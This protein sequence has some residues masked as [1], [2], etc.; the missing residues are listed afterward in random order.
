MA[1]RGQ[2][3]LVLVII[4]VLGGALIVGTALTPGLGPVAIGTKAP[5]FRALHLASRDSV[6]L[7]RYEGNVVLLNVW[8]TWC[9]PCE[10]EMPSIQRLYDELNPLGL[11]VLAVSVDEGSP[12]RVQEWIDERGFTFEILHDQSGNIERTYQ[13]I[14]VPETFIIDRDGVIVKKVIGATEWD[15]PT[16]TT[17]LRQLLAQ[18]PD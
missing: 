6:G 7:D 9:I 13:T 8:A 16:H 11:E 12:D 15:H 2:W 18:T 10:A 17:L 4:G 1:Q 14:G 3:I 5:D